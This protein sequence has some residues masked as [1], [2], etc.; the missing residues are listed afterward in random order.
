MWWCFDAQGLRANHNSPLKWFSFVIIFSLTLEN[1]KSSVAVG[2]HRIPKLKCDGVW[3]NV[4]NDGK[5]HLLWFV[6]S[7]SADK[8]PSYH[9]APS[10]HGGR[11][12]RWLTVLTVTKVNILQ[13]KACDAWQLVAIEHVSFSATKSFAIN[14]QNVLESTHL[15]HG[16]TTSKTHEIFA[17]YKEVNAVY[18]YL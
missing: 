18:S 12:G 15:R 5:C 17:F 13:I 6:C 11:R 8:A 14:C 16:H 10:Y 1:Q 3:D 2:W 4:P 7:Q 9:M